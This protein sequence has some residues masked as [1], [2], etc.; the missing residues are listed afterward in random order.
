MGRYLE[1][2]EYKRNAFKVFVGRGIKRL[3]G[4]K[5]PR[6]VDNIKMDVR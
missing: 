5:R 1:R 3:L 2:I 6:L 4:R